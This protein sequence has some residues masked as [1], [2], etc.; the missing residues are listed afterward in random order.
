MDHTSPDNPGRILS[1]VKL[2]M[3]LFKTFPRILPIFL[4]MILCGCSYLNSYQEEGT[5]V[6]PG[7]REPVT[8][9]VD[10]ILSAFF[11]GRDAEKTRLVI[12]SR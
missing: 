11:V 2:T 9:F 10:E 3:K 1:T 4:S 7:L 8:V 5:L 6:L 12:T